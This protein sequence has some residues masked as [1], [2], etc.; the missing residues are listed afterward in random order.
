MRPD[1]ALL[2]LL[3]VAPTLAAQDAQPAPEPASE[4]T[5]DLVERYREFVSTLAD[6]AME[7]RLPGEPGAEMAA[8][9]I[10]G[11]F[12]RLHLEPAFPQTSTADDGTEVLTP[13]A[14][15]RQPMELGA[16]ARVTA[17]VVSIAG[18]V[19][20]LGQDFTVLGLSASGKFEGT[21]TFVGYSI[22]SGPK[23]YLGYAPNTNLG[24]KAALMLRFEPM[25]ELGASK[26]ADEGWTRNSMLTAKVAAAQRRGAKAA[27]V[28]TPPDAADDRVGRLADTSETLD[29]QGY[30][31]IPVIM[32]T[33]E[34]ADRLVKAGDP[35]HRALNDLKVLADTEQTIVEL[36]EVQV[37]IDVTIESAP[38]STDNMGAVLPGRGDLADEYVVISGHYDH[39][40][41][42]EWGSLAPDRA[43]EIHPG[44]DDNA[45]GAAGVLLAAEIMRDAYD[46][47]P[48]DQPARSI[49]FLSFTAE[50]SGLDGSRFYLEH[51]IVP[52][53]SHALDLNMDMV[54]RMRDGF[55]FV[56]GVESGEGLLDLAQPHFTES[57]LGIT[58]APGIESGRSDHA[59]F[60]AKRIPFLHFTTGG[61]AEY[62]TPDDTID[63]IE[64]EG[65]VRVLTLLTDIARDEATREGHMAYTGERLRQSL[66]A[67]DQSRPR[68]RV[69]LVPAA[70]SPRAGVLVRAVA[71]DSPT[72][73]AGLEAGDRI[74]TWNGKDVADAQAWAQLLLESSPGDTVEVT[75]FRNETEITRRIRLKGVGEE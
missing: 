73:D 31:D 35:Q 38:I 62:H 46:K 26:W 2:A 75:F 13:R 64:V 10:Q 63:T 19:L 57:G 1:R 58:T 72:A 14:T 6:P 24:D 40:G 8:S 5:L 30:F 28:V 66:A 3:L 47:L 45:S 4:P 22:P 20:T 48:P 27:I 25:N 21:C 18:E 74:T 55:L 33:P 69:G 39:I 54:G 17:A 51:P 34:V 7:G 56:A 43:G 50:E 59:N 68:V 53:E 67:K 52:T 60:D 32:I 65:A 36:P 9:Y 42:G 70:R 61:H 49:L 15:Y 12:T 44:A 11:V 41:R 71:P 16:D 29:G 37:S 23:G